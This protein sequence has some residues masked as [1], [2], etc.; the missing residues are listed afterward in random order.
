MTT[1]FRGKRACSCLI[2]WLPAYEAELKRRGVIVEC[3]DIYQLIGGA[4]AS[5]GTHLGGGAYDIAQV[6]PEAILVAREM[7]AAAW[8]RPYNWDRAGGIQHHH[9]ILRGCPHNQYGTYQIKALDMG[10]NG[11]GKGGMGG[12]DDGPRF[13]THRTWREGIEWA[14]A[15]KPKTLPPRIKQTRQDLK[16]IIAGVKADIK[17]LQA[18]RTV[19]MK[20][21]E[22]T[23]IHTRAIKSLKNA[24]R[25][26]KKGRK[27]LLN[28]PK[29]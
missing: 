29:R 14:K 5:A 16:P 22:E 13:T 26:L 15:Q 12:P 8:H 2:E 6:S 18:A 7:G 19:A 17:R 4:V 10:Y 28:I 3:I 25:R 21:G 27:R 24:K 9:G 20:K 23:L 11:L 1:M